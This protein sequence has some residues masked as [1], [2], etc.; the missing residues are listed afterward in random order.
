MPPA[1]S[2]P[3]PA[4]ALAV[5]DLD[6]T[7]PLI[8]PNQS[9]SYSE[10]QTAN[11]PV[12][13]VLAADA[14]GVVSFRFSATGTSTSAD[15]FFSIDNAGVIT[16][17]AAGVAAGVA[18]NDFETSP[19]SFSYDLQALDAAGNLSA[20]SCHRTGRHRSR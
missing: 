14:V 19:N 20:P 16:I 1:T 18:Q 9:F 2:P 17:T 6:D 8:T 3:P 15:G 11:S 4:I 12:A 13:T 10:N 5:T 7:A